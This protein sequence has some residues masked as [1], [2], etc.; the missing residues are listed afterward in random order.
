MEIQS[1]GLL[2]SIA[3]QGNINTI[4][5]KGNCPSFLQILSEIRETNPISAKDMFSVAFP[6]N[7]VSVKA[8]NCDIASK[9]WERKDFPVWK[10]FQDD[11]SADS[12]NNWKP[13]GAEPTGA[14]SYI[15]QELKKIG[16][17]EMVVMLPES[18]QKKME[19]DPEYTQKI[20]EKLQKWKTD[21]DRMDNAVAASYGDDPILYQMTKSYCIQLDEN[22]NVKNYTV[23]SGGIDTKKSD[24]TNKTYNK[25]PQ[26]TVVKKIKQKS[27]QGETA[28]TITR[29]EEID[30]TNIAPYLV[31]F[32][33]KREI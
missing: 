15:Q 22:G 6:T 17:G 9:I 5:D 27:I 24:D 29:F 8:G 7:D 21:Y 1:L 11:V 16:F 4:A 23:V 25:M 20:A 10:Y 28:N 26:R 3:A 2:S 18:L 13:T 14:E 31:D 12:L 30:Y 19:A 33:K 32:Y